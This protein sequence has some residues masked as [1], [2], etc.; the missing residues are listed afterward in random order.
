MSIKFCMGTVYINVLEF[1]L[2][3]YLCVS[4]KIPERIKPIY[5]ILGLICLVCLYSEIIG[6]L[7]ISGGDLVNSYLLTFGK[8]TEEMFG[9]ETMIQVFFY[10]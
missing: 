7:L 4:T 5:E 1:L 3:G 2:N 8:K 9:L 6:L 10:F